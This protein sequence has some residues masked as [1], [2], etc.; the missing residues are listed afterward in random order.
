MKNVA[1]NGRF[2]SQRVTGV[3][4]VA[5]ELLREIGRGRGGAPVE[6]I[7]PADGEIMKIDGVRS[8]RSWG[9]RGVFWEQLILPWLCTNSTLINFSN[10]APIFK[11]RQ[12]VILHDAA[13]FDMPEHFSLLFRMW[14]RLMFRTLMRTSKKVFTVSYFSRDRLSIHLGVDPS[15][16]HV[17]HLGCD[18]IDRLVADNEILAQHSLVRDQY[19]LA[20]SSINPT[21]NFARLVEAFSNLGSDPLMKLVIVGGTNE[22]VFSAARSSDIGNA[23][24]VIHVGYVSDQKVKALYQN[25]ACFAFPSVYEGFGIPPL[26]AMRCRCPVLAAR[27][28]SL[29]E[30]CG[31]AVVYCDPYSVD[32]IR[33]RLSEILGDAD[34]REQL[35]EKGFARTKKFVWSESVRTFLKQVALN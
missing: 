18:H 17:M 29:P 3:Q 13:V 5:R 32:D 6:V 28:A 20:V 1:I 10:S 33:Q 21:K 30:V 25:A 7:L 12:I 34:L 31:D 9:G 16:I 22:A 35:R 14:Y 23:A 27:A 19:V 26:E 4:R 24:N 2:A 15:A 8:Q 11:R